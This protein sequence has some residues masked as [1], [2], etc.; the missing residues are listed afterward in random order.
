MDLLTSFFLM[1]GGNHTGDVAGV[2]R[3]LSDR[4]FGALGD[5]QMRAR[6]A[7]GVNSLVWLLWHMARTEDVAVNLV[8]TAGTQVLDDTWA[9]RMNID[10]RHIGSGMSSD[11]VDHL[12]ARANIDEVRAYRSAV[13]RRTRDVVRAFPAASWDEVIGHEDIDRAKRV[14][15]L[16]VGD[17]PYPWV[18]SS[19]WQR[20][21]SSAGGHNILHH[22]E[23]I[24]I[25]GLGGFGVDM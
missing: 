1:H 20:L 16:H 19:R 21:M 15:A 9:R 22:G 8:M 7:K 17:V 25:R 11:E 24:T 5:D 3:T 6:P 13:G 14:G 4:V 23:A 10:D 12:T 2:E 18:G